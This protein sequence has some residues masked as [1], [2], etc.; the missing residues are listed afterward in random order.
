MRWA[1]RKTLIAIICAAGLFSIAAATELLWPARVITRTQVIGVIGTR[2]VYVDVPFYQDATTIAEK[3]CG[4]GN[5]NVSGYERPAL[6]L[7]TKAKYNCHPETRPL[8]P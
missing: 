5:W 8:E 7:R 4:P 2:F 3:H 1:R 6:I